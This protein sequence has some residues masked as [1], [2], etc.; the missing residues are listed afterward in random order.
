MR[1]YFDAIGPPRRRRDGRA[2]GRGRDRGHPARRHLPRAGR[3]QGVLHGALHRDPGLRDDARP[4][5]GR[6]ATSRRPVAHDRAL[7]RGGRSRA[8][9]PPASAS[10]CAASTGSRS[11]TARSSATRRSPTAW[12]FARAIGLLPPQGSAPRRR[13]SAPSTRSP[14]CA[15]RSADVLAPDGDPRRL[16]VGLVWWVVAWALGVKAFDAFLVTVAHDVTAA[17]ARDTCSPFVDQLRSARSPRPRTT[18][19][20]LAS[21]RTPPP[22]RSPRP[23]PSQVGHRIRQRH[24]LDPR[25][26]QRGHRAPPAARRRRRSRR[27]RAAS[28]ARGRTP[29]AC[30]RAGRGRARSRASRSRCAASIS[31]SSSWPIPPR[32]SW[33][34]SS[35]SPATVSIVPSRGHG[36]LGHDDDREVAP[37]R[38]AAPDQAA[39]LVDVERPL[40]DQDH[41]GAA[42]DPGVQRDPARVAA[43]HLDDEHA[44]VGSRPWCG[45]GRSRRWRS[46]RRCRSRTSGRCRR[47]RCRSSSAPRARGTPARRAGAPRRR[48]C[49]RRRSRSGRRA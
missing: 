4:R 36:A 10:S 8:S 25:A 42:G 5:R 29:S 35:V 21:R 39:D 1:S 17:A 31:R 37:A 7:H 3:G 14:S 32:R 24:Q 40:G 6:R 46:A 27:S 26:A 38:V 23:A 48:A 20:R 33:P 30:R 9:S 45:G 22:P 2:L 41:V 12:R 49:P 28:R 13:C 43:H 34:N 11:R 18:A 15:A 16:H 19:A 47:G 44:V